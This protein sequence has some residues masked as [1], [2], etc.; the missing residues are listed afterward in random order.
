MEY[1]ENGQAVRNMSI[2]LS[3]GGIAPGFRRN[4]YPDLAAIADGPLPSAWG[5]DNIRFS[6]LGDRIASELELNTYG[7]HELSDLN[8]NN[9]LRQETPEGPKY[10]IIDIG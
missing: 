2:A 3:R 9:L 7:K 4:E 5:H 10:T 6:E 8:G 1:V